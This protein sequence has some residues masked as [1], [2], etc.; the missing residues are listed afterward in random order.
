M[1]PPNIGIG[2]LR[3][4]APGRG[5]GSDAPAGVNPSSLD[6]EAMLRRVKAEGFQSGLGV[7]IAPEAGV[8]LS[9]EQM[10]RVAAATDLAQAH[11]ASRALVS[12]DG[13]NLV[14]DVNVRRI[15]A[16]VDLQPGLPLTGIDA[17]VKV[18]DS[19]AGVAA[20]GGKPAAIGSPLSSS[21]PLTNPSLLAA[22]SRASS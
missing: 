20:G 17:V 14:V 10:Q 16:K 1:T 18:P 19:G 12:I 22:L 4:L 13:L 7:S 2:L 3:A 9:D 15:A 11:G 5:A 21:L 8:E 6:F